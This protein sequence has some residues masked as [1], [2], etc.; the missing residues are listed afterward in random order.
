MK[1]LFSGTIQVF[2][3]AV[4]LLFGAVAC[5]QRA[6]ERFFGIQLWSVR[7]AMGADPE[8]T[9]A[10]LGEM[11]YGFIEA[12]GYADGK[13]YG[14]EPLEFLRLVENN[15]MLFLSSHVGRNLP[16]PEQWDEAM[17]WWRKCIEAHAQ[18]GVRFIV[19]PWLG[20]GGPPTLERLQAFCRY[21]EAIGEMANARG[22][23]FGFHNHAEEF[24]SIDGHVIL[25]YMLANTNPEKVFFQMDIYWAFVGNADPVDYFKRFPGRFE[26]WHVKDET[27]VGASGK[28][29]F[30]RI[31]QHAGEAG[32]KYSIV[33]QEA[34]NYDPLESVRVS[35]EFLLNSDFAK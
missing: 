3:I 28:I 9:L 30:E 23:R 32:L 7:D 29:D 24:E 21:L 1:N 16:E 12:A 33:E 6:D 17:E 18:A 2:L 15:G 11:G 26:L 35:L 34:F 20:L 5:N 25:D 4:F 10:A 27:E 8:G 14:M 19:K 31:Y 13:F 22:I